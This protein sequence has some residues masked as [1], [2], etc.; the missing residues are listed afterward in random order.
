MIIT[1]QIL[2]FHSDNNFVI[3]SKH[4]TKLS[5]IIYRNNIAHALSYSLCKINLMIIY[6]L[7][8]LQLTR[9][10]NRNL[11]NLQRHNETSRATMCN[12]NARFS[13]F[14]L[15]LSVWKEFMP[16]TILGLICTEAGLHNHIF[17]NCA[18]PF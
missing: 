12:Y 5:H 15:H 4:I 9:H 8:E 11:S 18:R 2:F 16:L 13:Y 1:F 7:I 3:L 17:I 10:H 14:L 6:M